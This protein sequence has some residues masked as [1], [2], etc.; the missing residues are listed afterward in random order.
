MTEVK[1]KN[2]SSGEEDQ[3]ESEL[4]EELPF[5]DEIESE[6]SAFSDTINISA[7]FTSE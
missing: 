7:L 2:S 1:R 3:E 4:V 6:S 5:K